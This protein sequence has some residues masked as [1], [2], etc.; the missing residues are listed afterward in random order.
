MTIDHA[1]VRFVFEPLPIRVLGYACLNHIKILPCISTHDSR[2]NF[3]LVWAE[4]AWRPSWSTP[5]KSERLSLAVRWPDQPPVLQPQAVRV[6]DAQSWTALFRAFISHQ[7][8]SAYLTIG[9]SL[10]DELFG[11][12]D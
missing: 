2:P 12:L 7:Q 5:G 4:Q 1:F 9:F 11:Q 8:P 10:V 6:I 3:N